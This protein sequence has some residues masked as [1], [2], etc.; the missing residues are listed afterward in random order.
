MENKSKVKLGVSLYS[1]Q[2]QYKLKKMTL[3]DCFAHIASMGATGVEIVPEQTMTDFQY[4][5]MDDAFIG[6]WNDLVA[7]YGLI[8]TNVGFYDDYDVFPNRELNQQERFARFKH[9]VVLSKAMGF[10]SVRATNEM[11]IE[12]LEKCMRYAGDSGMQ[13][14]MEIHS[15]FS[16]K[17]SYCQDWLELIDRTGSVEFAGIYP[18]CGTFAKG[19]FVGSVR[20][21]LRHGAKQEII[22]FLQEEYEKAYKRMQ[23]EAKIVDLALYRDIVAYGMEEPFAKAIEMGGSTLETSLFK[24]LNYDDPRW[25]LEYKPYVK[26]M[27]AKFHNMEPDGKG[28]YHDPAVDLEGAMEVLREGDFD[29]FVSTEYEGDGAYTDIEYE[30]EVPDSRDLV[31]KQQALMRSILYK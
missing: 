15:P 6:Y 23:A 14:I 4:E 5:T 21:A 1:Y 22:D 28:M 25:L 30:G 18:D 2:H 13:F 26:H 27:H 17:S 29:I 19:P 10:R 20:K 9:C 31:E 24:R 16:M 11:P 8:P 7:K 3:E 12:L